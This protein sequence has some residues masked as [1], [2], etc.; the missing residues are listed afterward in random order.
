MEF[1]HKIWQYAVSSSRRWR[2][3]I[4]MKCIYAAMQSK[5]L[6]HDSCTEILWISWLILNKLPKMEGSVTEVDGSAKLLV[7]LL[8]SSSENWHQRLKLY[9]NIFDIDSEQI[10][11]ILWSLW[12]WKL[13][14][15]LNNL[16]FLI[17]LILWLNLKE[18]PIGNFNKPSIFQTFDSCFRFL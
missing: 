2:V 11:V 10:D 18:S 4:G 7:L 8:S 12:P 17:W 6:S 5:L 13:R 1:N 3:L 16:L 9:K 15:Q 14:Q